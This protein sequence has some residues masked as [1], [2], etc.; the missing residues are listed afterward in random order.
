[1]CYR[2]RCGGGSLR[3]R[4]MRQS[5]ALDLIDTSCR[6][7]YR[8]I[9][10]IEPTD[11]VRVCLP[12]VH[13]NSLILDFSERVHHHGIAYISFHFRRG[14]ARFDRFSRAFRCI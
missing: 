10:R 4:G 5:A 14:K 12:P 11:Q 8:N 6:H 13:I 2:V 7:H 9:E 3:G 1:M